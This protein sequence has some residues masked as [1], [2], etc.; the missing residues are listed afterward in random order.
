MLTALALIGHADGADRRPSFVVILADDLGYG[1]TSPYGGWIATPELDRMAAEG[2]RFTDFHSSGNVCS[3]TR[4]GLLTGRYQQR[5]GIP[6]VVF[7]DAKRAAHYTG[8]Q[9]SEVTLAESLKDA[10]Y[11]TALFGKWHLGYQPQYNPVHHGFDEFRGYVSGNVDYHS[12]RDNQNREDWWHGLEK[13]PEEGYVT[14]LITRHAEEFIRRHRERPFFLLDAHQAVHDPYQGPGETILRGPDSVADHAELRDVKDIYRDMMIE[15]DR[16]IG[17]TLSVLRETGIAED[18]FVFFFSDNGANRHGS[19]QP[20]RGF[21]GGDWEGGHRVPF[22]AR[23]PG[24]I[25]AGSVS[26]AL[27][28]NIDLLATVAALT[29]R[30]LGADEGPDSFDLLPAFT[31]PGGTEVRGSLLIAP[32]Q[33]KNL[34]LRRGDWMYIGAQGGGGFAERK[35]GDHTFGGPAAHRFTGH[36]NSD[37]ENGEIRP[38]APEAQ[39]YHL[40]RDPRQLKNVIREHA[41]VAAELKQELEAILARPTA[42]HARS[43]GY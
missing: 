34:S 36:V 35:V 38:D 12:H 40:G 2:L 17:R 16:S 33:P 25:E 8:L 30:K 3:P 23:W 1:D 5:A 26:D 4:A 31:G 28:S 32:A 27:V 24:R 18:T 20:W 9:S 11:A 43:A 6:G 22:I 15:L 21:K 10:G 39:L 13:S 37:I 7:A 41:G 42:P 14:H 29:G 19:N